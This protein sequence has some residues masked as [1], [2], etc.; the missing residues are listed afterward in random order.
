MIDVTFQL[1]LYFLLTTE[2]RE[3]EGQ[4]PGSI[5]GP[6]INTRQVLRPPTV[7]ITLRSTGEM[8]Q[9][10]QYEVDDRP[11]VDDPLVLRQ[12]L[13][14]AANDLDRD[15]TVINLKCVGSVRWKYV[16][17]AYNAAVHNSFGKISFH[18]PD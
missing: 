11:P 15:E 14:Y 18:R 13:E 10:C 8:F 9:S 7:T 2:F 17:E 16:V 3:D 12:T 6:G 5:C 4:I 1:L